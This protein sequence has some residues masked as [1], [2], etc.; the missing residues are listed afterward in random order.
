MYWVYLLKIY[1][2]YM[3]LSKLDSEFTTVAPK[4]PRLPT[5]F[6]GTISTQSSKAKSYMSSSISPLTLHIRSLSQKCQ[7]DLKISV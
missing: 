2:K 4:L 7:F 1:C 3:K 6:D 5:L